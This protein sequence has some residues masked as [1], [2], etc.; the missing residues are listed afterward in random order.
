[1][2]PPHAYAALRQKTWSITFC[3]NLTINV[4]FLHL[5]CQSTCKKTEVKCDV[6][7][8]VRAPHPD[9]DPQGTT[10]PLRNH[11]CRTTCLTV[12]NILEKQCMRKWHGGAD[13]K[14][15]SGRERLKVLV[16][17]TRRFLQC[18]KRY[19]QYHPLDQQQ[20]NTKLTQA[21]NTI[22]SEA[23]LNVRL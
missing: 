17:S 3:T 14:R 8:V 12:M 9:V 22:K 23:T 5:T 7:D 1:M 15:W 18:N 13:F 6:V 2:K 10:S 21:H 11:N 19:L 4:T 20:Q 16:N